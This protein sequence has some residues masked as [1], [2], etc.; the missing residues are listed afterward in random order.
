MDSVNDE[1]YVVDAV[2]ELDWVN[3]CDGETMFDM[4]NVWDDIY[5]P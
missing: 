1:V 2:N 3:V 4:V 5:V